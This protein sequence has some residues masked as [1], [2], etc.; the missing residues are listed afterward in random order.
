MAHIEGEII[1]DRPVE[2]VFDFVADERNEPRF[3]PS[4]LSAEKTSP[5]PIGKGTRFWAEIG[6]M[7]GKTAEMSI[8]FTAFERPRLLGSSTH[9]STMDIQGTLTFEPVPRGTRM[10]WSWETEPRGVFKL[11]KPMI[12]RMG[13]RQEQAIWTG[14]K[15]LLERQEAPLR[16]T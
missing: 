11:M 14:L 6:T 10:C 3:N 7:M 16:Q 12:A 2:E 8:E 4:I 1:I 15:H 9:L 13:R 5:G